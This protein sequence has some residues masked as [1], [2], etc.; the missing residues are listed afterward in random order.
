MRAAHALRPT[1]VRN[2]HLPLLV[3]AT[4]SD[5]PSDQ[6]L[7]RKQVQRLIAPVVPGVGEDGLDVVE[8]SGVTGEGVPAVAQWIEHVLTDPAF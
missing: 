1:G 8:V 7:T 6:L 5:L 4:H 2:R 3:L